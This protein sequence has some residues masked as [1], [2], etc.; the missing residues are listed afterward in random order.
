MIRISKKWVAMF[1][2]L[3]IPELKYEIFTVKTGISN[4]QVFGIINFKFQ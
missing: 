1:I 2:S 4:L 3:G